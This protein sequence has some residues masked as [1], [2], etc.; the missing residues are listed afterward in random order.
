MEFP[1]LSIHLSLPAYGF[2][3]RMEDQRTVEEQI[4]KHKKSI[5]NSTCMAHCHIMWR[6]R[7][8]FGC[9]RVEGFVANRVLAT[10]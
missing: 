10:S 6:I 9:V 3:L 8:T 7:Y 4:E 1:E 5:S 2:R